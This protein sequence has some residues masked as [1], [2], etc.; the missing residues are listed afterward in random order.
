MIGENKSVNYT[1]EL[2]APERFF[3]RSPHAIVTLV[4]R[5]KGAVSSEMLTEAVGKLQQRHTLLRTRI[6]SDGHQ[7]QRF[8]TE[9]C[10][11]IPIQIVP[12]SSSEDWIEIHAA[13]VREAFDFN[14]RPPIRF[15]LVQSSE[16]SDLIIVCHHVICDGMSLAYLTRDMMTFLGEPAREVEVLPAPA[17]IELENF[18]SDVSQSFIVKAVIKRMNRKWAEKSE[19]FDL[20]D[21]QTLNQAYWD[22]YDHELFSIELS[23]EDTARL[24]ARCK[25]ENTTVNSALTAAYCGAQ[26]SVQGKQDYHSRIVVAASV[27]DRIPK[28]PGEGMGM[29]AGGIN[30]KF[31]Y[32][33]GYGFWANAREFNQQF[34]AAYTN[35]N[36]FSDINNWLYLD[37]TILDAIPFKE[38]GGLVPADAERYQ[39]IS[40]FRN[41]DDVVARILKQD[42]LD[43]LSTKLWGTAVTN[44]GRMDFPSRYGAL[45]L[46]RIIFQPGGGIPLANVNLVLGAVTCAGKLSLV[47]EYAPQAVEHSTVEKI[48]ATALAWLLEE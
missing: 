38:L 16:E 4:A 27:R 21:Y 12:R 47:V 25:I 5:I 23:E 24:V 30:L 22:N 45:Q 41:Q 28:S 36:L 1:R 43:S 14:N 9:G 31:E 7:E 34:R 13:A 48:N 33:S 3:L 19:Y 15:I 44:L 10:G 8:T 37:A 26:M 35:K 17:P 29:Y 32:N 39:K 2:T 42:G 6:Q 20:E 11:D 18:P 46:E 40:R